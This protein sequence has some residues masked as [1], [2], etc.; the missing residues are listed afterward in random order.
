MTLKGLSNYKRGENEYEEVHHS[1]C[2]IVG[3]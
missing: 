3:G 2:C 1:E